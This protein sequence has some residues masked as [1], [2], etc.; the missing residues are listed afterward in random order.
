V[1]GCFQESWSYE[2]R[3][4]IKM[5]IAV[6]NDVFF[7]FPFIVA[8]IVYSITEVTFDQFPIACDVINAVCH[9]RR[10]VIILHNV[11]PNVTMLFMIIACVC[12]LRSH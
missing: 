9:T 8:F 11:F 3:D 2:L 12:F 4:D 6:P 10:G 7:F 1:N 5:P